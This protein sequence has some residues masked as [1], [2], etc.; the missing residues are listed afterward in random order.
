VLRDLLADAGV[1]G[2]VALRG[3]QMAGCLCGAPVLRPAD[4][5][6]SGFMQ[7]RSSDIPGAGYAM[8]ADAPPDLLRRMMASWSH[9]G[10]H[11]G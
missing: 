3:G 11:A 2:V 10:W 9:H 1:T 6:F 7:P 5:L 8:A 4:Y